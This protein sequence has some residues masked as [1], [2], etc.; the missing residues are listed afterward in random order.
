VYG[1]ALDLVRSN[2]DLSNVTLCSY[3]HNN[4]DFIRSSIPT[5]LNL[6]FNR[7]IITDWSSSQP[8]K[9]TLK[10]VTDPRVDILRVEGQDHRWLS[11]MRNLAGDI[12]ETDYVF[13]IEPFV[14]LRKLELD[15]YPGEFYHGAD[16]ASGCCLLYTSVYH[17]VNGYCEYYVTSIGEVQ[18]LYSRLYRHRFSKILMPEGM[19]SFIPKIPG[20]DVVVK[21]PNIGMWWED[22]VHE[23][24]PYTIFNM[25]APS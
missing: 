13:F 16:V 11:K 2:M 17:L 21:E 19:E 22:S 12:V 10:D 24:I 6:P 18:D 15:P 7:I 9:D 8:L 23:V 4:N 25:A 14:W 20:L 5:W 3:C 1:I